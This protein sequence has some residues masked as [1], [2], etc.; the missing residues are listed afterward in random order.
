MNTRAAAAS[1]LSTGRWQAATREAIACVTLGLRQA[2]SVRA[3]LT[4]VLVWLIAALGWLVI[5]IVFREQVIHV[6]A[7]VGIVVFGGVLWLV[8]GGRTATTAVTMSHVTG[9]GLG[10][11][12]GWGAMALLY[13]VLVVGTARI[14]VELLLMPTIQRKT[15]KHYPELKDPGYRSGSDSAALSMRNTVGPWI[16]TF[17]GFIV[18]LFIPI[19]G[20]VAM[21]LLLSY[22]N[23]RSLINDAADDV[24]TAEQVR[25]ILVHSRL[26][27]LV[28]GVMLTGMS[29]VPL[30]GMLAPWFTGGAVCHFV[31]RRLSAQRNRRP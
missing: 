6:A 24:A 8:G 27:M 12:I 5:F 29:L 14:A 3:V 26:E 13:V 17:S 9:I 15:L 16:G 2:L 20:G 10:L 31:M 30:L 25:H 11:L 1:T 18:C 23:V 28:L 7:V 19:I 22:M 21:F 4:S